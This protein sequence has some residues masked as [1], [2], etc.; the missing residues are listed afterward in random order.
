MAIY[1]SK[2][3]QAYPQCAV[4]RYFA[5]NQLAG[6]T[7]VSFCFLQMSGVVRSLL[8]ALKTT[9]IQIN[10]MAGGGFDILPLSECN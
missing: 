7:S 5:G 10:I 4:Q 3:L 8:D 2:N 6:T 1:S 9:I